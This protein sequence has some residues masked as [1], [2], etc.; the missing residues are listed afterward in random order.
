MAEVWNLAF[1]ETNTI[2]SA[3][4]P[5]TSVLPCADMVSCYPRRIDPCKEESLQ[6][7]PEKIWGVSLGS[8]GSNCRILILAHKA[9]VS[10]NI[11]TEDSSELA[12]K[13]LF[14]HGITSPNKKASTGV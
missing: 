1:Q 11:S 9:T 6:S 12:F 10:F 4:P 2:C 3:P 5:L 14:S 8:Q 7:A 13:A